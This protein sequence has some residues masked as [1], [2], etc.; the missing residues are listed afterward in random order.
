MTQCNNGLFKEKDI[1]AS[2]LPVFAGNGCANILLF[3]AVSNYCN[4]SSCFQ[5]IR[6]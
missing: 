4:F 6:Q 5:F 2:V 1:G 3:F